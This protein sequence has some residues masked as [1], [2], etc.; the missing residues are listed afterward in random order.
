MDLSITDHEFFS[1]IEYKYRISDGYITLLNKNLSERE[2]NIAEY[3]KSMIFFS[4]DK[5]NIYN[6]FQT[7]IP[8]LKQQGFKILVCN[9]QPKL[10]EGRILID[11]I[12]H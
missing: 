3:Y 4:M 7:L 6:Y 2:K 10:L 9:S 12:F 5:D 11:G 1:Q 8:K